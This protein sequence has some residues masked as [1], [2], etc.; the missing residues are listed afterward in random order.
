MTNQNPNENQENQDLLP[1]LTSKDLVKLEIEKLITATKSS[2]SDI[3][4]FAVDQ[5]WKLLQ[6]AVAS[7]IQIIEIVGTDLS[8]PQKKELA[9]SML[10]KFYDS[11]FIAVDIPFIPSIIEA[12]IHSYVKQFLMILVS[13]SI[14]SMVK[15]F[16]ETGVF[17]PKL[18]Y[19]KHFTV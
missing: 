10:S 7:T 13:S 16:R 12:Y 19:Q 8:S 15:I 1:N 14:D 4:R 6:L 9:M 2:V 3:K 5:T 17:R 11:I 18:A